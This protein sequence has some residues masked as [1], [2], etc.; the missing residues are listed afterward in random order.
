VIVLTRL[1]HSR[2]WAQREAELLA[3]SAVSPILATQVVRAQAGVLFLDGRR[4][5]PRAQA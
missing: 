4:P 2:F 5:W 3:V 1:S